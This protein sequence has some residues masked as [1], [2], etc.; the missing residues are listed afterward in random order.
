M[1]NNNN[2]R[3][4]HVSPGVYT[5]EIDLTYASKSLGITKLGLAGETVKGPAFQPIAI[6]NWREFQRYFG[7]TSTAKF[8]GSK[9]PKYELPY[10]AQS[11]LKQSNQ[12]QVCR[13]LGLSGVN[14][15]PAWVITAS[16]A[17]NSDGK[18][19]DMEYNNMVVA[20]LRSRGEHRNALLKKAKDE[21]AGQCEDEYE[22]DGIK[23]Y[24]KKVWL[25]RSDSLQFTEGCN[26][27]FDLNTDDFTVDALNYGRFNIIVANDEATDDEI[28]EIGSLISQAN[29]S[30][31]PDDLANNVRE[32]V[33][34]HSGSFSM[35]SVSL[36]AGEQDYILNV[37]GTNAENGDAEVF[38]EELY[39]VALR[40][41]IEEGK[42]TA[43][44]HEL[45]VFPNY[46]IVPKYAPVDDVIN[47]TESVLRRKDV[48]KRFLY[49]KN[50]SVDENGDP[51]K[52]HY[53]NDGW[54][55]Y[56]ESEGKEGW[57]YK[58]VPFTL[59]NGQRVYYYAAEAKENT[60]SD[61]SDNTERVGD[62]HEEV[63]R[64]ET[65]KTNVFE[66][67][68]KVASDGTVYMYDADSD[69]CEVVEIDMNNYK[70]E[71]RYASTPW[72]VSEMKGSATNVEL[73]RMFRFHTISDGNN[74]NTEVKVSI[75]NI[76]PDYGTFD[77]LVR[78]FYDTDANK[79]VY[80]KF[81]GVNMVPGTE[82]YIAKRIGSFDES[83][84]NVSK[85]I[86]VEVNNTDVV[87]NAIPSGFMGYPVR[88]Y[89][90]FGF[91]DVSQFGE[92]PDGFKAPYLRYNTSVDDEIRI[93]KQYFGLSD[94][95]GID[96][97]V[98]KYKGYEAYDYSPE[99]MTPGFHLD[100]RIFSGKPNENGYVEYTYGETTISQRVSVDGVIG[101]EWNTVNKNNTTMYGVEPKFGTSETMANTI[102]E[103]KRYRKFTVAFCGGWDGWDYYRTSRSNGDD[104]KYIKYRGN[105]NPDSGEGDNFKVIRHP[106]L[107]NF[108]S[109]DKVITSDWYAY[110]SAIRAFANPKDYDINVFATPGID[111]VNQNSLVGEVITM[112]EEER[113]DSVYVLT[114][115]DK[116]YGASDSVTDMFTPSQAV[117]NLDDAEIDS[118]YC[119][120]YFPWV[121]YYDADN[122]KYIYLP[123]TRDVVK[124]MA[125]TDNTR[126]PWFPAAGWTRGDLDSTAVKPKK[127]LKLSEQDELYANR[128]NFINNF[129]QDGMK[130]WGDN[131]MQVYESQ[132]NKISKRR[133]LLH[134][135]K[136][137]AVA[138]IGL[139]FDP[140]DATTKQSFESAVKPILDN[141]LGNR[142]ITDWRL[143]ID[144]S[145]EA[146]DRLEL[147]ARIYLKLQPNLEYIDI[148]FIITP[149]GVNFDD[150]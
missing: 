47:V 139:I 87:R 130:I 113:A 94:I 6:E 128:I 51:I 65:E 55:T 60:V 69:K 42:I 35:Y 79:I 63:S 45:L 53:T 39:D 26:S 22:F 52:V 90:G 8:R 117:D 72:I 1:A 5:R 131:N 62:W 27:N 103:D 58:V 122:Q 33:E 77:V 102:Y 135:R 108:N 93:N 4:T 100:S 44:N 36:N 129:A 144:D 40:Q 68:V 20:V 71:Y 41:L 17:E 57:I 101:F 146:R 59:G 91:Q 136:L 12:L 80:E 98:L 96:E 15:G 109:D 21:A 29:A 30:T 88:N 64:M 107:Y 150:I 11:Y 66:E 99:G 105:I 43:I 23:Y 49:I 38:V 37:I 85:Y 141:V 82:N 142:G 7:G 125:L 78:E 13:V 124:N 19:G 70:E 134:I 143:E 132:M 123:P 112:I 9:F 10:I 67:A 25:F 18:E 116:P 137:C 104:F 133:L 126:F 149:S 119:C 120:T 16:A 127:S 86:T 83:Y 140:N 50:V 54:K 97:D 14:A 118:N 2:A 106:E 114:T 145:Q 61:P 115:P 89:N 81:K 95:C 28:E 138:A 48:G 34:L 92:T 75:E 32:F 84:E 24:A 31:S 3:Q 121:K 76:D 111:Y 46:N 148:S 73:T 74:A 110:L 56:T 147:P